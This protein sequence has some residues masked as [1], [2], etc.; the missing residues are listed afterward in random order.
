MILYECQR[1]WGVL[2]GNMHVPIIGMLQERKCFV[3][4]RLLFID[5]V[6]C[7]HLERP[8][9]LLRLHVYF[10]GDDLLT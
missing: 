2:G 8:I 3:S 1:E 5:V 6:S 10:G 7:H 4:I 9:F